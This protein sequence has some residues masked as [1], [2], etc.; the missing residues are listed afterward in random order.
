[1]AKRLSLP[2]RE[3][4]AARKQFIKV[5][6]QSPARLAEVYP[7]IRELL[8]ELRGLGVLTAVCT[9]KIE[10]VALD[11]LERLQLRG[12]F[13][14]I[15]GSRDDR[16]MKPDPRPLVEAV[17]RAGGRIE[18]TLLVGDTGADNG[19]AIA[20]GIPVVLVDD[21]Y[22][23]M[24]ISALAYGIIVDNAESLRAAVLAFV[25][26]DQTLRPDTK[27]YR[28]AGRR[29][30][31]DIERRINVLPR[32]PWASR[33]P[34]T[35]VTRGVFLVLGQIDLILEMHMRTALIAI[36][37]MAA[38]FLQIQ[39]AVAAPR[40][41][42]IGDLICT[43]G[44]QEK[45]NNV[46][47][48]A[49]GAQVSAVKQIC[50]AYS[51]IRRPAPRR[52]TMAVFSAGQRNYDFAGRDDADLVREHFFD[53]QDQGGVLDQRYEAEASD[54]NKAPDIVAG[55]KKPGVTL[56]LVAETKKDSAFLALLSRTSGSWRPRLRLFILLKPRLPR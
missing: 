7:G 54:A 35:F 14:A 9:N 53:H 32:V 27:T 11:I 31:F 26:M 17:A 18:R 23:H 16:P 52:L 13:D 24:P 44:G 38:A 1:M 6:S 39:S 47:D 37:M 36:V 8:Q 19:A 34:V 10:P 43:L 56:Q 5:Y 46:G 20:A 15:V 51:A 41:D 50:S 30:T 22:S 49:S 2:A 40:A 42:E 25:N 21:G 48:V 3:A 28:T 12:L 33:S 45:N 29:S 4:D 55:D